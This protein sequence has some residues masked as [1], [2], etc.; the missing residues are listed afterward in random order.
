MRYYRKKIEKKKTHPTIKVDMMYIALA[1][2]FHS[3]ISIYIEMISALA[4]IIP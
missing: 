4:N 3:N 1:N 2:L